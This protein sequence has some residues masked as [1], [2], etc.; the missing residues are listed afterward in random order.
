MTRVIFYARSAEAHHNH[1]QSVCND[2]SLRAACRVRNQTPPFRALKSFNVIDC[3]PPD[4]MHDLLEGVMPVIIKLV[5]DKCV[6]AVFFYEKS[7][8]APAE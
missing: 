6:D 7:I 5:V 8:Y 4:C 2:E 3:L 1:V